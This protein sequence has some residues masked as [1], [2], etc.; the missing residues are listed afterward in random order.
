MKNYWNVEVP[1]EGDLN[2][3]QGWSVL[4]KIQ[5]KL[6]LAMSRLGASPWASSDDPS[7]LTSKEKGDLRALMHRL[8]DVTNRIGLD[9]LDRLADI[10]IA[11]LRSQVLAG[12]SAVQLF[13][14]WAGALHPRAYQRHVLPA[15]Q[16]VLAAVAD[17]G[18][19]RLHFGVGTSELLPL[20]R[21]AGADVV[22][23]DFRTQLGAARDRLGPNTAVQGNLDPAIVLADWPVVKA[24]AQAVLDDNAG[25]PGHIFNLGHGVLPQTN[26]DTLGRLVDFVHS[27]PPIT[28]Q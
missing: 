26:P 28:E 15:S 20:M 9:V 19:P 1:K 27:A 22:G 2:R 25:R 18:V 13:D 5:T 4:S 3:E 14:S 6:S 8:K 11:S 7:P 12:A 10:A 17:L 21:D 24:E 23:I 16:K